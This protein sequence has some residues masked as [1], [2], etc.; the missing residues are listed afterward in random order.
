M[1][2]YYS[3]HKVG[4]DL[5]AATDRMKHNFE[6]DNRLS[7]IELLLIS[8]PAQPEYGFGFF[9]VDNTSCSGEE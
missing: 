6:R 7:R 2:E 8:A 4:H 5:G 9:G 3:Q 1:E